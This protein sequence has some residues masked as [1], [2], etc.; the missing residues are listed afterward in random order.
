MAPIPT[1]FNTDIPSLPSMSASE[2][3][4]HRDR[5]IR[6]WLRCL[7]TL[8]PTEYTANDANRTTLAFFTVCALDLLGALQSHTTDAARHDYISWVYR[9][10]HPAGGFR[11]FPGTDLGKESAPHNARW[12]PAN[13]PATYFALVTLVILGDDLARVDR[14]RCLEWVVQLQREDGSFGDVLDKDTGNPGGGMDTRF[15]YSAA[16]VRFML[17]REGKQ[18][19]DI[20]VDALVRYLNSCEVR[21]QVGP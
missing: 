19:A 2:P 21:R 4:L 17:W 16:A 1:H 15:C 7:K 6:Y 10:Q 9:Q 13:L 14:G 20:D 3:I 18:E 5:H 8:L 11:G 12:D